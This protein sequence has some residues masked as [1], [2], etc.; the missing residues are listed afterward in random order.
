MAHYLSQL[1]L[2][3]S[4]RFNVDAVTAVRD[5]SVHM[6]QEAYVAINK[7]NNTG[8]EF[9]KMTKPEIAAFASLFFEQMWGM[10]ALKRVAAIIKAYNEG[11]GNMGDGGFA[12]RAGRYIGK[13]NIPITCRNVV[14]FFGE[15]VARSPRQNMDLNGLLLNIASFRLGRAYTKL[16]KGFEKEDPKV[17][18]HL[19]KP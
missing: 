3:L 10:P 17:L 14:N 9:V 13:R 8:K 2:D 12:T 18:R 15:C 19:R 6:M 11:A 4:N 16:M 7:P 1:V 5:N